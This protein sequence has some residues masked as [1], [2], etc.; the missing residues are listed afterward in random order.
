M[1]FAMLMVGFS[2]SFTPGAVLVNGTYPAPPILVQKGDS[3]HIT[4][5]NRLVSVIPLKLFKCKLLDVIAY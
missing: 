5:N 1:L 2:F 3:L 4:L